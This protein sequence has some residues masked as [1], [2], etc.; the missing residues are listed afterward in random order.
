MKAVYGARRRD[1]V[2]PENLAAALAA[3]T[4]RVLQCNRCEHEVAAFVQMH[5]QAV[6][7]CAANGL[8]L[9]VLCFECTQLAPDA[10]ADMKAAQRAL[11][12]SHSRAALITEARGGAVEVVELEVEPVIPSKGAGY[13]N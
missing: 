3:G 5:D 2:P 9:E 1:Q 11:F 6:R 10:S 12:E 4:A 8:A 7:E 13:A